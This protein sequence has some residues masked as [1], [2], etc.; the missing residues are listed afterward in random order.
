[1]A[2]VVDFVEDGE[3]VLMARVRENDDGKSSERRHGTLP[4]YD[5]YVAAICERVAFDVVCEDKNDEVADGDES[6]DGGIFEGVEAAEKGEGY[7]YQP[8]LRVSRKEMGR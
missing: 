3:H 7:H 6:D 1:M 8:A 2:V 4:M 5:V